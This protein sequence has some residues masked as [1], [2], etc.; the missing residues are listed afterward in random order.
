MSRRWSYCS[1]SIADAFVDAHNATVDQLEAARATLRRIAEAMGCG[2]CIGDE[3][4]VEAVRLL[5][6][7][8]ERL[9][10]YKCTHVRRLD[11]AERLWSVLGCGKFDEDIE[12]AVRLLVR[13]RDEAVRRADA[14]RERADKERVVRERDFAREEATAFHDLS[15]EIL[16]DEMNAARAVKDSDTLRELA[17][18][19]CIEARRQ[20][21]Y[22][23]ETT[24]NVAGAARGLIAALAGVAEE[25]ER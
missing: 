25:L 16:P 18:R 17:W 14:E 6:R 10:N 23:D 1:D 9:E 4:L 2:D 5:D 22:A 24:R 21:E 8:A 12:A 7:R 13:E 15:R 3:D 19:W 11:L 20:M